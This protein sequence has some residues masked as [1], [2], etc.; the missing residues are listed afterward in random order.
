MKNVENADIIVFDDIYPDNKSLF[1]EIEFNEY[2]KMDCDIKIVTSNP[3]FNT[4]SD[5]YNNYFGQNPSNINKI[6]SYDEN[7][8]Y[9][10][11]LAYVV[12]FSNLVKFDLGYS[13]KIPFIVNLYP[14]GQFQINNIECDEL[15][16]KYFFSPYLRKVIVTQ[17]LTYDYLVDNHL[18]P[19]EKI[20]HI[21]GVV[22]SN[23]NDKIISKKYF[24]IDKEVLDVCFVAYK[25]SSNGI[26]KGFDT[27]IEVSKL[28][29]HKYNNI[30]FHVVGNFSENDIDISEIQDRIIFWGTQKGEWFDEFYA[31]KDIIVSPT[32]PFILSKGSFDG[33]PTASVSEAS[34]RNV[35]MIVTDKLNLNDNRFEK[36]NEIVITNNDAHEIAKKIEF[37]YHNP[38]ELAVLADKGCQK[39]R[40]IYSK[41]NQIE[42]RK[43]ILK[44]EINMSR[45][46]PIMHCFDN[47]YVIQ[48]AVSMYSML[49]HVNTK[50]NYILYV[51]HTDITV[52]NQTRLQQT[53]SQFPNAQLIFINMN[54]RFK[55]LW[56]EIVFN[57]YYSKEVLYKL[58][59]PSIFPQHDKLIITDVDV[60]FLS[61]I[62][63]SYNCF[64]NNPKAL[65]AG[66]KQVCPRNSWLEQFY[67]SCYNNGD[68][69]EN[70]LSKLKTC[71][72]YLVFNLEN[73]RKQ[74]TEKKFIEYLA[75]NANILKQSEQDVI[76]FCLDDED[77][78]HLPLNYVVCSYMYDLFYDKATLNSDHHYTE[79]EIVSAMKQPIQLHYATKTKPWNAV[80]CTKTDI[81]FEYL[82]QSGMI[83]EYF[84]KISSQNSD[85]PVVINDC[86][87]ITYAENCE[88]KKMISIICCTYNHEAFIRQALDGIFNQITD[89]DYEV[90]IADDASTDNTQKII[91]EYE[92]KYP[93]KI[94]SLFRKANVGIGANYYEALSLANGKYLAICDGDDCWIDNN[95][96]QTQVDFLENNPDYTV[97]C[98]SFNQHFISRDIEDRIFN[99]DDY[100]K[101]SYVIKDHYYFSDLL[102]CRFV[103]SCTAVL[104]WKLKGNVPYFLKSYSV[105][106]LPLILIH[107]AFGKVKVF[108]DNV[109]SQYNI[110]ENGITSSYQQETLKDNIIMVICEVNQFLNFKFDKVIQE[111]FNAIK[112]LESE[113]PTETDDSEQN[114]YKEIIFVKAIKTIYKYLVPEL[115]Q[116]LYRQ[117]KR[118]LK[119]SYNF[120]IKRD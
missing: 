120:L 18:C 75:K 3:D 25:Y 33:F 80:T 72:G 58:I 57:G 86:S 92:M 100:I 20:E 66:V 47:N 90:I 95:K 8:F 6:V 45:A 89:Y 30:R 78:I 48:A 74:D 98:S 117:L 83:N 79:Q 43:Q 52:Q 67:E 65:I 59:V 38:K 28:L 101:E 1:R 85:E 88:S 44:N 102:N 4:R 96:L 82:A 115:F 9:S 50:N 104:R 40:Y 7:T 73:M 77:V 113:C 81:W 14:G 60:V 41:Q 118:L 15:Y 11:K 93:G 32:E 27:F 70:A 68:F 29:A 5:Q 69:G 39:S 53:I 26:D 106:D 17:K 109:F 42:R 111:Y 55:E 62:S 46:I 12:F 51:L 97:C 10:A 21:F 94:V 107:S 99:V 110:H 63:E 36:D 91:K 24:S 119:K 114:E 56:E 2:L 87:N 31:D 34:I 103:A 71:G 116:A 84:Q 22:L 13:I 76:N 16:K 64:D 19:V 112:L 61:D 49:K 37:F 35:A 23:Y 105:I 54:N 108:S